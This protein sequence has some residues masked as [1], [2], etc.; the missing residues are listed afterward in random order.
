MNSVL[1]LA[2]ATI[3]LYPALP[4]GEP[5]LD[6]P[7]WPGACAENLRLPRA[8]EEIESTTT[9]NA[10]RQY[11]TLGEL[12]EIHIERIWM[13]EGVTFLP[14]QP[15]RGGKYVLNIAWEDREAGKCYQRT[16]YGV[17]IRDDSVAS[18]GVLHFLENQQFRAE[19]MVEESHSI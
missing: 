11:E 10:Y 4:D 2:D 3:S 1:V 13:V 12:L 6:L 15:V 5:N 9:G 7:I 18:Q 17:Q 16:Y 19:Y 14:F 8:F